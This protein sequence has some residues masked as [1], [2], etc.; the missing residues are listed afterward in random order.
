MPGFWRKLFK[1]INPAGVF[2]AI[3]LLVGIYFISLTDPDWFNWAQVLVLDPHHEQLGLVLGMLSF[4]APW[5]RTEHL[6]VLYEV[7][8]LL[9]VL[10]FA[11]MAVTH[12]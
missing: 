1:R 12:P 2:L 11:S 7:V 10:W 9:L 6:R 3:L 4:V 8:S 5:V